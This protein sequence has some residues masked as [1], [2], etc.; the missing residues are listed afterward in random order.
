MNSVSSNVANAT[1]T[2]RRAIQQNNSHKRRYERYNAIMIT[3]T[4]SLVVCGALLALKMRVPIPILGQGCTAAIIL[5][6]TYD[7]IYIT[8]S[9]LDI[10][11]RD[12]MDFDKIDSDA[13]GLPSRGTLADMQNIALANSA[14]SSAVCSGQACCS[15]TTT[16]DTTTNTCI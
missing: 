11:K 15:S 5:I 9:F 8:T 12:R 13:A 10:Q 4:F 14:S 6:L 2:E 1:E 3:L 16:W 7:I